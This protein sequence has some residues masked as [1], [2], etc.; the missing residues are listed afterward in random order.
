MSVS[1]KRRSFLV[2]A[3]GV[4]AVMAACQQGPSTRL[5]G[6]T[7]AQHASALV[8]AK[9]VGCDTISRVSTTSGVAST[10]V[11]ICADTGARRYGPHNAPLG[12][13]KP[14]ARMQNLGQGVEARW[15]LIPGNHYYLVW[16]HG[17]ASNMRW[18]IR[19]RQVDT[20]GPYRGCSFHRMPDSSYASFGTCVQNRPLV[21]RSIGRGPAE[22]GGEDMKEH[23]L[24]NK[25]TGPAW[26][27]CTDGC[28]TTDAT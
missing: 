27:S 11:E 2:V 15:G 16:I 13:G 9:W 26:V 12:P 3:L 19:G 28:C 8:L 22:G 1:L 5:E 7:T 20:S 4:V 17:P 6:V 18:T 23:L 25:A 24:L 21:G 14:V 10:D